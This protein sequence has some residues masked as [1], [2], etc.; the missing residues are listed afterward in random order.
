MLHPLIVFL[1][2]ATLQ[3]ADET[4]V[5]LRARFTK[6]CRGLAL[7]QSYRASVRPE[8]WFVARETPA[9][10]QGGADARAA[11]RTVGITFVAGEPLAMRAELPSRREGEAPPIVLSWKLGDRVVVQDPRGALHSIDLSFESFEP[12]RERG[13]GEPAQRTVPGATG[14]AEHEDRSRVVPLRIGRL[15]S[16]AA[17]FAPHLLLAGIDGKIEDEVSRAAVEDGE[18]LT[19]TLRK[20]CVR[21]LLPRA[22]LVFLARGEAATPT[23]Q[24]TLSVEL[25]ASKVVRRI[26]LLRSS[27]APPAGQGPAAASPPRELAAGR[28]VIE[29]EALGAATPIVPSEVSARLL[30]KP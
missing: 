9:P 15:M 10:L 21:Q 2:L 8:N 25:D 16:S 29:I 12:P 30:R 14:E 18:V 4:A 11:P 3:A 6:A 26:V 13:E 17:S 22:G 20:E 1:S 5:D 24:V 28:I 19:A 23:P 7:A 27:G